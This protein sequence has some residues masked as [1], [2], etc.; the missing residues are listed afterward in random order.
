MKQ[1]LFNSKIGP[2]YFVASE[3][4]LRGIFWKKQAAPFIQ[5][6]KECAILKE[7]VRQVEEYLDGKR[8]GFDLPLEP[9]GTEF[10]MK[11]WKELARIPY[12]KTISYTEL[13]RKIRNEKAV[14]AVG[15]ANGR[16]PLSLVI[17]CHRVIAADGT[18]GGY[19]GGLEIKKRL[20]E[21]ESS[22]A[23]QP[24]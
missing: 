10:Q 23:L 15:T 8:N 5:S 7:A 6:F 17:P 13:A 11:V 21:L 18:L 20:L 4:A 16:N 14:R 1:H 12:G 9:I 2:L 19:A 22:A 24:R 3:N